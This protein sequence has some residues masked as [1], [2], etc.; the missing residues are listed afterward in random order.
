MTTATPAPVVPAVPSTTPAWFIKGVALIV[1]LAGPAVAWVDPTGHI[2]TPAAQAIVIL[3]F[4]VVAAVI[5]TVHVALAAVHEYGYSKAAFEHAASAEDAEFK[6]LWPEFTAAWGE[7]K[8]LLGNLPDFSAVAGEVADLKERVAAIPAGQTEAALA[9]LRGAL[10]AGVPAVEVVE[11][12]G[13]V[14][15]APIATGA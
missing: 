6:Q 10:G 5:F 2:D 12:P 11:A 3:G 1:A 4:L 13:H 7:A 15:A 14:E 9:V 8:P